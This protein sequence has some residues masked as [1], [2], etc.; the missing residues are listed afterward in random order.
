MDLIG[1]DGWNRIQEVELDI[2]AVL[3]LAMILSDKLLLLE[4]VG[5]EYDLYFRRLIL[6]RTL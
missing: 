1:V 4:A 5:V 3:Q 6:S 2:P